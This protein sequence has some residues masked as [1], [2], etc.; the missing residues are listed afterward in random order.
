[1]ASALDQ[2][3]D[4]DLNAYI[5]ESHASVIYDVLE[6]EPVNLDNVEDKIQYM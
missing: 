1:V 5:E 2:V 6:T 4:S 3:S